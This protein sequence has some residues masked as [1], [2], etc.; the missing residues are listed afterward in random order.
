[1]RKERGSAEI[2]GVIL[3]IGVI[4]TVFG[5]FAAL[6]I[7]SMK[8]DAIPQ[9]K[10]NIACGNSEISDEDITDYPCMRGAF[11]CHAFDNHSCEEDCRYRD[12]SS[13]PQY[14]SENP[15]IEVLRCLE[16]CE[17]S[18]CSDLS[19]C[20]ILY[21]CHNGG[22]SLKISDL[23]ITINGIS[24]SN[25][26]STSWRLKQGDSIYPY[27]DSSEKT[28]RNGDLLL[29]PNP[30]YSTSVKTIHIIYTLPSGSDI[31]LVMNQYSVR[32]TTS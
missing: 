17:K 7:P 1:M 21:I 31:T 11:G 30:Y 18:T 10:L 8:P 29:I 32:D 9:V 19:N 3:L 6:Y 16:N 20:K 25:T 26:D 12:Y 23:K 13:N 28:F 15:D 2:V 22:D 14:N 27:P 24:V 5:V 4:I